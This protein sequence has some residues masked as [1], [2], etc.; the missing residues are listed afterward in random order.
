MAKI[1][2]VIG[3]ILLI[4]SFGLHTFII[5]GDKHKRPRYTRKP[6]LMLMPWL[7]GLILP[8]IAWGQLTPLHWSW[9]VVLNFV[10]VFFCSPFITRA[11]LFI[12]FKTR[13]IS[14]KMITTVTLGLTLLILGSILH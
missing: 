9:L 10:F 1:L 13:R 3:A 12:H 14:K 4:S 2:L 5:S 7:C 8:V 6:Y 11:M